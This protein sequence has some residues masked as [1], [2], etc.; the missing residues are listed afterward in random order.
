MRVVL[1]GLLLTFGSASVSQAATFTVT[2]LAD[3]GAGSLRAAI[4]Q[5][6]ASAG[7]DT[8]DFTVSGTIVLESTLP[9]ITD[10]AGLTIDGAGRSVTISGNHSVQVMVVWVG[11]VLE[12]KNLT[13][14]NGRASDGGGII[15]LG[16]LSVTSSTLSGNSATS[17]GG[18]VMNL[19]ARLTITGSTFS[20]NSANQGGAVFN[21]GDANINNGTFSGNSAVNGGAISTIRVINLVNSTLTGNV[22]SNAGGGIYGDAEQGV[23]GVNLRNSTLSGNSAANAGG[24]IYLTPAN[25]LTIDNSTFSGNTSTAGGGIWGT[26]WPVAVTNSTFSGSAIYDPFAGDGFA[27]SLSNTIVANSACSGVADGGY[28]IDTGTNCGFTAATSQSN[29]AGLLLDPLGLRDNGGPTQTIALQAGSAALDVIPNG[30]SGC[31]A[32]GQT[33]QR[34]VTR[35][36]E[37]GC[38]IGAFER[39]AFAF[40]FTGFFAPLGNLPTIN[41]VKAGSAVPVKFSL[42][43]DHGLDVLAGS[44]TAPAIACTPGNPTD[45]V[46]E[47]VTAGSSGLQ[48]DPITLTYTFVWKTDKAFANTCR[49]LQITL[50]DGSVHKARFQFSR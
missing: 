42:G 19:D 11:A 21:R 23:P 44:P 29:V 32:T 17:W 48:F 5:A 18:G 3:S 13:I 41:V 46:T 35:P 12:V 47:V 4:D 45:N 37:F 9:N 2:N 49:E 7:A 1:I 10:T 34:G 22:A 50:T 25:P 6:N 33:D 16:T 40:T 26:G 39:E 31:G 28:N 38:D 43:G 15:N 14:A 30:I 36:Q 27:L 20:G 8:I 24:G